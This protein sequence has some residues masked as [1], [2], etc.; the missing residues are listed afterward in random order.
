M[1]ASDA[2]GGPLTRFAA[3]TAIGMYDK[4][5]DLASVLRVFQQSADSKLADTDIYCDTMT[6]CIASRNFKVCMLQTLRLEF[7]MHDSMFACGC[8]CSCAQCRIYLTV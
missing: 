8:S 4:E 1:Q 6:S 2:L 3:R 5:R 7:A